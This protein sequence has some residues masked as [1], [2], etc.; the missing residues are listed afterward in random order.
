VS[1][2][3]WEKVGNSLDD[4]AKAT[5]VDEVIEI[6]NRYFAEDWAASTDGDA[7][8]P[9]SGG[10]RQ[11][12]GALRAAGFNVIW[13]EACYFYVAEDRYGKLLTYIEGDVYRGDRRTPA[14]SGAA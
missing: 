3:F 13:A 5:T 6:L 1:Q 8:F 4:I 11:L 12:N 14:G 10:D 9:G 7:L 2:Q